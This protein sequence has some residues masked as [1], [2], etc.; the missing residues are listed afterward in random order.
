MYSCNLFK[1]PFFFFLNSFVHAHITLIVFFKANFLLNLRAIK[2][3]LILNHF[4]HEVFV[5]ICTIKQVS[6]HLTVTV[7][8]IC[9]K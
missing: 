5:I 9:W 6:V 2:Y 7:H 8:Q 4:M 3:Y 1:H